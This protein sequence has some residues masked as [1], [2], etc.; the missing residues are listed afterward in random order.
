MT[1]SG[2]NIEEQ[3]MAREMIFQQMNKA[4][5]MEET[6]AMMEGRVSDPKFAQQKMQHEMI[7][8]KIKGPEFNNVQQMMMR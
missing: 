3:I 5:A 1:Q 4:W 7:A 6:K 2:L 8:Q